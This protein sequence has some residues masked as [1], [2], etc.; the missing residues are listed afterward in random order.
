[1]TN[2]TV[3]DVKAW[4]WNKDSL[5]IMEMQAVELQALCT[6]YNLKLAKT[7]KVAVATAIVNHLMVPRDDV[8]TKQDVHN[9]IKVTMEQVVE[10]IMTPTMEAKI[11]TVTGQ[12]EMLQNKLDEMAKSFDTMQNSGEKWKEVVGRKVDKVANKVDRSMDAH[13]VKAREANIQVTG[14]TMSKGETSKQLMELV[15][16]EL[17]DRLKVAD[18]VQ[19]QKVHRQMLSRQLDKA[20]DKAS[21]VIITLASIHNKLMVLC[22][23]KGL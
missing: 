15:Q 4:E 20:N 6:R 13:L 3:F 19:V 21:V 5:T 2:A 11:G 23:R 8:V 12:V 17:F 9:A 16:T 10:N 7:G 1:M 18:C 22:A 14:L